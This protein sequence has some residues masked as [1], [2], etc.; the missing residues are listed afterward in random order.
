M[1]APKSLR[2]FLIRLVEPV[3]PPLLLAAGCLVLALGAFSPLWLDVLALL[4]CVVLCLDTAARYRQYRMLRTALRRANGV[5]G[6]AKVLFRRART[7]WCTRRAALAA[8]HAEGYGRE[9]RAL[10]GRWGYRPWHVFPDG[11]FT[12]QSPFL[13]P[14]FWLSVVGLGPHDRRYSG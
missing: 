1:S 10:V 13:K 11:T 4:G 2:P 7:T 14:A 12:R 9:A 5:S 3:W 6:R 8:A